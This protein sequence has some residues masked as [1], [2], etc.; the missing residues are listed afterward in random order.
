MDDTQKMLRAIINGL[1]AFK[2][3]VLARFNKTDQKIESLDK[4]IDRVEQNLT[5]RIDKI[6]LQLAYLEDDT[7]TKEEFDNLEKRVDKIGQAGA[8]L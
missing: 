4:K 5:A 7:P 2:Q 6:G 8:S 3:E 1:S